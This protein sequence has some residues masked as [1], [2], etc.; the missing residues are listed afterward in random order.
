[1]LVSKFPIYI[2]KHT[3]SVMR[4]IIRADASPSV[5]TGH[6][7]RSST[8]AAEFIKLGHTVYYT[9]SIDPMSLILERFQ[10]IGV[11]YPV[12]DPL[13]IEPNH[14]NDILLIDSYSLNPSD[15][16]FAKKNGEK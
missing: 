12:L 14:T 9:G 4:L 7:M 6:V 3:L 15:P 13:S 5:G 11:P 10:E 1:M 2:A 16:F 8:I